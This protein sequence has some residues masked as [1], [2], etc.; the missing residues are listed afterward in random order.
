MVVPSPWIESLYSIVK[1]HDGWWRSQLT[2]SGLWR[3]I[4]MNGDQVVVLASGF[5]DCS[6]EKLQGSLEL[7]VVLTSVR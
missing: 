4:S 6:V 2:G 1:K 3:K 5:L 7:L